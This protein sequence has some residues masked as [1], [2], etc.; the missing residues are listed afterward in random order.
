V[1]TCLDV[2]AW[3]EP[4]EDEGIK[5]REGVGE[6][7]GLLAGNF[8]FRGFSINNDVPDVDF[9][10]SREA[11]RNLL[12]ACLITLTDASVAPAAVLVSAE[13]SAG[14]AVLTVRCDPGENS[15]EAT[16]PFAVAY[17]EIDWS[18]VQALA[19]A[20]SVELFRTADQIVMRIPRA[21]ATSPLQ[22][23]PV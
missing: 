22:I 5:L 19:V 1:L 11:L 14:V 3:I 13:V 7:L 2:A 9:E 10:V 12:S 20:E 4:G 6:C 17:R 15:A 16:P 18:D 23:V 21:I 8:N